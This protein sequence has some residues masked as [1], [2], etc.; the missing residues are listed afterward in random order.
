MQ[1]T[2][3]QKGGEGGK[4][5]PEGRGPDSSSSSSA[6]AARAIL[7][8]RAPTSVHAVALEGASLSVADARGRIFL[9]D[10]ARNAG[11][12]LCSASTPVGGPGALKLLTS[13]EAVAGSSNGQVACFR[14]DGGGR[15]SDGDSAAL[16]KGHHREAVHTVAAWPPAEAPRYL[17]TASRDAA[18]IWR[19]E[20]GG[21]WQKVKVLAPG[22]P[23]TILHAALTA[24][25]GGSDSWRRSGGDESDGGGSDDGG[26]GDGGGGN[27][28][29]G[30]SDGGGWRSGRKTS[31]CVAVLTA[32]SRI[33]LWRWQIPPAA[34]G[35]SKR[36]SS[37]RG[38]WET[39]APTGFEPRCVLSRAGA[40]F[41]TFDVAPGGTLLA[42]GGQM[43]AAGAA[44]GSGGGSLNSEPAHSPQCDATICFWECRAEVAALFAAAL[45]LPRAAGSVRQLRVVDGG[46]HAV[47]LGGDGVVYVVSVDVTAGVAALHGRLRSDSSFTAIDCSG[48]SSG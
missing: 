28:D 21:R 19:I 9:A 47:A 45:T 17:L 16:Y 14:D 42:A 11:K 7:V 46:G 10:L 31:L 15:G 37:N 41:F 8:L 22:A 44:A 18:V 1:A 25:P 2:L 12:L 33:A 27:S 30:S 38:D 6:G 20:S 26:S 23:G 13:G 40:S 24:N 36:D 5:W 29:R 32:E 4:I 39:E 48:G 34:N 43:V 35:Q 3:P